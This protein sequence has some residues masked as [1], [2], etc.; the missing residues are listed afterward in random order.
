MN[1]GTTEFYTVN[2]AVNTI[3]ILPGNVTSY[4]TVILS[5]LGQSN[6]ALPNVT[7]GSVT[8][9]GDLICKGQN[10]ESWLAMSWDPTTTYGAINPKTVYVKGNLLVQS[11]SFIFAFNAATAQSIVIDGDVVV[12]PGAGIDLYRATANTMSIG[13]SLIN[14]S[15]NTGP[16]IWGGHA[17]SNVRLVRT[18]GNAGICNVTFFGSNNGS[19]T[20][21]PALSAAPN[22]TFNKVTVNKG[23]SQATTMTWDITG[24]LTTPI[25][26]WLTLQNG[27]LIYRRTGDF[28]I[29]QG[30][31]FTI[32]GTTGLTLNTPSNVY[33]ANSATNNKTFVP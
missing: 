26:D 18:D 32:P 16:A 19:V 8:I 27:T 24:S 9:Y 17:G 13:G 10:W 2:P 28:T 3:F 25:D 6:L 14:N 30:T 15:D 7:G 21:N 29:S 23:T 4:G 11:G 31:N 12:N 20:N 33:I 5:P 1:R 22:T